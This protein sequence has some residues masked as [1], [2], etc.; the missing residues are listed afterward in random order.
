MTFRA[1]LL[2]AAFCMP[3]APAFAQA[4]AQPAAQTPVRNAAGE[5]LHRLFAD[6]D[7]ANLRRNPVSALFRSD[8]R[9]LDQLGDG[10]S[11]AYYAAERTAA[12]QE[13]AALGRI[14]R[15]ALSA[16][17]RIAYDVFKFQRENNLANLQ[18]AILSLTAVRPINHMGGIH[19]FYPQLAS[20][21]SAAP[22]R[23]V[24]DYD[25]N[26]RRHR[27]FGPAIDRI[28]VRFREGMAS[29][30]VDSQLTIRNV[31]SQ[32]D[33]QL[34]GPV[35]D[36]PFYGPVRNFPEAVPEAE[37]PRLTRELAAA[38]SGELRPAYQRLRDFLQNE[39]LPRAREGVGLVHMQGGERLYNRLIED[40][41]TLPMTAAE[42]H[43][44]G[45]SEVARIRGEMDAIR[46][47]G[48]LHRHA[49]AILRIPADRPPVRAGEPRMDQH[50][51]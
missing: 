44:L 4:A 17:D 31:I 1:F 19:L 20:G 40:N 8:Y 35:E 25:A 51:L 13:L 36:S 42:V 39:Y 33:N 21:T 34:N 26:I 2:A 12:E 3:A 27:Q 43:A 15:N 49:R 47:A 37:R 29:G 30:V 18:P 32:L 41:T 23:N 14:D 16:T 50:H 48:E 6:S 28:I 22:F 24:G 45:L 5:Q 10:I 46:T 9:Y 11:D 7:E 38:I